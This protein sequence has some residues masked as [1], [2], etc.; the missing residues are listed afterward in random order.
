MVGRE[1]KSYHR[2][3]RIKGQLKNGIEKEL[4]IVDV[5]IPYEM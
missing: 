4:I 2:V 5:E 1:E 3:M